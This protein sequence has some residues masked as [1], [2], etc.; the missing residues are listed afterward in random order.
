MKN[1]TDR[2]TYKNKDYKN[3]DEIKRSQP[4]TPMVFMIFI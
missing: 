4:Y 3:E 1:N 2:S